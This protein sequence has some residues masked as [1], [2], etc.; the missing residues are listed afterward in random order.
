VLQVIVEELIVALAYFLLSLSLSLS[1]SLIEM[2]VGG[3]NHSNSKRHLARL[4]V[5]VACL[6]PLRSWTLPPNTTTS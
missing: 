6:I 3:G 4:S 5:I 1:L 2:G